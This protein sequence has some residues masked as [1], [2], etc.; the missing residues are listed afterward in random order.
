MLSFK[1]FLAESGRASDDQGKLHELLTGAHLNRLIHGAH[2]HMSHFRDETGKTPEVAHNDIASRMSH[3]DYQKQSN[4]A[5][6]AA[7]KIHKHLQEHHPELLKSS[8]DH[9]VRVSWTSQPADH[10]NLTGKKD[11]GAHAGG[12][13]VMISRHDKTGHTTHAVGYSL[14]R[15]SGKIT[16]SNRGAG[17][18]EREFGMK[19][20]ALTEHD[21][22]H[23]ERTSKIL[24]KHNKTGKPLTQAAKHLIYKSARDAKNRTPHQQK[25][26]DDIHASDR[27]RNTKQA[28]A[29][30]AHLTKNKHLVAP[31]IS[32]KHTFP[33]YQA[34]TSPGKTTKITDTHEKVEKVLGKGDFNVKHEGG[35]VRITHKKTG[36]TLADLEV[37]SKGKP[38][39]HASN[40]CPHISKALENA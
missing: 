35:F 18:T 2:A 8:K 34:E 20:G 4:E 38:A 40:V 10:E 5:A 26:M 23:D 30:A 6:D 3:E 14:K 32:P 12:A 13:D 9:H 21:K 24:E 37:R 11:I 15:A 39:G 33:H 25:M 16:L 19:E 27:E 36:A 17:S 28:E 7:E 1:E 31:F 29:L 22:D